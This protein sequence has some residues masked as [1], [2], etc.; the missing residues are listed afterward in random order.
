MAKALMADVTW[1]GKAASY[2]IK[3]WGKFEK[4]RTRQ[5]DDAELV[6][7]A[8]T[9]KGFSVYVHPEK[10]A[11]AAKTTTEPDETPTPAS[12]PKSPRRGRR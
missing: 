2:S 1:N 9:V 11:K 7:F 12:K 10:T 6:K 8:G 3:P 4:G 5:T